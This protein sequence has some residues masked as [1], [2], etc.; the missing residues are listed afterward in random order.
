M[1]GTKFFKNFPSIEYSFGDNEAPVP[2]EDLSV[3]VDTFDQVREDYIYYQSYFIKNNQRPD[4]LSYEIYGTTD[5]YWTFF[6]NNEHLRISG[7]PLEN[8]DIYQ[9]AKLYYPKQVVSTN[10]VVLS[11]IFNEQTPLARSTQ[12][13][14][15]ATVWIPS[16]EI[17]TTVV[18]IDY[19]LATLYLATEVS[20]QGIG[21]TGEG[22]IINIISPETK[23]GIE[24]RYAQ[25]RADALETSAPYE[26][27]YFLDIPVLSEISVRAA[28]S[29]WDAIHHYE[30]IVEDPITLKKTIQWVYPTYS[31]EE[32]HAFDWTSVKTEESISYLQMLIAKNEDM[33][34]IS[35]L[36]PETIT[37]V[38][39]EFNDLLRQ[40]R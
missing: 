27:P 10:G 22:D 40:R 34:T 8:S 1:S 12:L 38:V 26:T 28:Y 30:R 37:Q 31:E 18:R 19:N 3:F 24:E 25:A 17:V 16:A 23:V 32:P 7:W 9:Q 13:V 29:G 36:R 20:L 15:G 2:F 14:V 5:Y 39:A 6:L 21:D 11:K 4:Q 35:V 33:R